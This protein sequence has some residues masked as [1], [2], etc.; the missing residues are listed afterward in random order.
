M[1]LLSMGGVHVIK[2][3]NVA[4]GVARHNLFDFPACGS[5]CCHTLPHA[6]HLTFLE[7]YWRN[8]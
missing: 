6:V 7:H 5:F 3:V 8:T 2:N 4:C 1:S